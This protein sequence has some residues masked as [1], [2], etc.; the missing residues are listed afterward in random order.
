M[1]IVA[2]LVDPDD[3][4]VMSVARAVQPDYLQ[5]HGRETPE[6]VAEIK[7]L[8]RL[9]VIKATGVTTADDVS[10]AL[11]YAEVADLLLFDAKAPRGSVTP[12]GNGVAF[13]WEALAPA[14]GKIDFVLSGGLSPDNVATAIA[15]TTPMAVDVSSGVESAPG[16]KDP[17]LIRHFLASVKTANKA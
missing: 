5:L 9:P 15:L 1:K 13:D 8:A 16:A 7:T 3:S 17:E 12:G 10:A 2:L 11:R 4:E 14:I 6:R